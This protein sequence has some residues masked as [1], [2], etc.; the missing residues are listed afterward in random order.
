M[1]VYNS[2]LDTLS[3]NSIIN[4][5]DMLNLLDHLDVIKLRAQKQ[6]EKGKQ[7]FDERGQLTPREPGV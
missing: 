6:S 1:P 5:R 4:R 2:Q 3:D 7:R